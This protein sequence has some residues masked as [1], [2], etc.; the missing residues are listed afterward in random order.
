MIP[1]VLDPEMASIALVGRGAIALSRLGWLRDGG[2]RD[3]AVFSD[4][5][6]PGLEEAAGEHLRRHLPDTAELAGFQV[7]WIADLP[8]ETA[9][10][11]AHA[12][13]RNGGLV[14]VE[15]VKQ[16]CDFH[17]PALVRRGDLLLTVSTNGRS[18]GLAARI[19]RQLADLF[20]PE[21]ADRLS[22]IGRKRRAWKRRERPLAELA[23]LTDATIDSKS[24][25]QAAPAAS[26]GPAAGQPAAGGLT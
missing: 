11:L 3:L 14:N 12:V 13:R 24:W 16:G 20:G 7:V 2:A 22:Q 4:R 26:T 8:L 10:P 9:L 25:L 6:S 5:P 15:D 19:R 1:I 21:W 17:N 23:R 18:P